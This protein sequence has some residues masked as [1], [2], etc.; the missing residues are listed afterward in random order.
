[1]NRTGK[2]IGVSCKN[3]SALIVIGMLCLAGCGSGDDTAANHQSFSVPKNPTPQ[4]LD[5]YSATQSCPYHSFVKRQSLLY[6]FQNMIDPFAPLMLP[7][8]RLGPSSG[9]LPE[10][11]KKGHIPA[12]LS[13]SLDMETLR[14]T[15]IV[16]APDYR[17]ALLEEPDGKGHEVRIGMTVGRNQGQVTEIFRD[18]ILIREILSDGTEHLQEIKLHEDTEE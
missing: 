15:G 8:D 10:T 11:G 3:I 18:G 2:I 16:F 17:I 13:E 12:P 14:L 9:V 6:D 7:L 1:M 5:A 4:V